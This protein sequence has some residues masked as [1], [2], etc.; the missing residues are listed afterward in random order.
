MSEPDLAQLP[1]GPL[2]A[3]YGDDFT[4]AAAVME[5]FAFAGLPA[6][7]FLDIPN[8]A[9]RARF[10][11]CRGIGIAGTARA[12]GPEW[13]D[14][15]LPPVFDWL[16]A[17]GAPLTHY[18]VCSTLDSSPTIGSIGH[19]I[20]IAAGQMRGAFV[21]CLIASPGIRRYQCFGHLFAAA[22]GGVFRLDRHPVMARHPVTP[23]DE[24]DVVLHLARQT[25]RQ[26][27]VLDIEA[28]AND[29]A[30]STALTALVDAG[31]QV[32]CMDTVTVE[33]LARCGA[34]LWERREAAPFVVG[35]QGIEEALV[36]H[37]QVTG[38]LPPA[39]ATPGAG[40]ARGMIVVSGS[41][42]PVTAAQID[43]SLGHGFTGI[44]LDAAAL[45]RGDA[46]H[47]A[48][49]ARVQDGALVA[50]AAGGDPLIYTA[51]GPDDPAVAALRHAQAA[52][53]AS[54]ER[55][56][57]MIGDALG[58][59]LAQLIRRTGIRRAVISGGDTSG[60]AS[61]HLGLFALTALAPTIPG[62][63]LFRAH[64]D[65]AAFDGLEL[66]LKGGQ[67]GTP[68]YCGWIRNGGGADGRPAAL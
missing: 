68:D 65:D 13:M 2:A 39:P 38:A 4:G 26:M 48:E 15:H 6:V 40:R 1:P 46:A 63:S 47:A 21:P 45:L 16:R 50:L 7:L 28:L 35:S 18:K 56:N 64:S 41:V 30:A 61:R 27:G 44:A 19:A 3:W 29:A 54:A 59:L 49:L 36:R 66:A 22:P 12:H 55:A 14:Q 32:I 43:W 33:H 9:Q 67:M 11:Q 57:A 42:S 53:G 51:R 20:D 24:A 31:R 34:L 8:A 23:M 52:S 37:W 17:L 5:I 60:Y 10:A 62:A 25:E 58:H